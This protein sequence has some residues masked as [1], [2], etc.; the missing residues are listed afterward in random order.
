MVL[1][2]SLKLLG[3]RN[4][5]VIFYLFYFY[6]HWSIVA[7][8]CHVRFCCTTKCHQSYV[9]YTYIPIFFISFSFRSP[10]SRIF[11]AIKVGSQVATLH[12][13]KFSCKFTVYK[14]M[15]SHFSCSSSFSHW[16]LKL[17]YALIVEYVT[18][19]IWNVAKG[20]RST[21]FHN[22]LSFCF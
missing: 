20:R 11:C 19:G 8:Q 13:S 17:R 3:P 18:S 2:Y 14:E 15:I 9:Q 16:Y 4:C 6:F 5:Y 10:L 1:L 22:Y 7:L 12:R 21:I